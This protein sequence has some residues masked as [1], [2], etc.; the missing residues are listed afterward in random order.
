MKRIN[1]NGL[2]ITG[3]GITEKVTETQRAKLNI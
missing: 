2:K 1:Q 3:I